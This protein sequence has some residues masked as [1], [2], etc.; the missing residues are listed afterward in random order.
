M[1]VDNKIIVWLNISIL[2]LFLMIFIGGMTRL[3]D[4]GL[5]MVTWKPIAGIF[6]PLGNE[7]WEQSFE[8]YK[9]YP[10]Y[11]IINFDINLKDYKYI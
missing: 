10:E 6:P 3:T 9:S 2:F 1:R 7:E 5:S 4:S 11:K 8:Q